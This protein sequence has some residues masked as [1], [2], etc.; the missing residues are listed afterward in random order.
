M[1]RSGS[2][3]VLLSTARAFAT[4]GAEHQ[5]VFVDHGRPATFVAD[6]TDLTDAF[7]EASQ[8]KHSG[9]QTQAGGTAGT[10]FVAR[11][12]VRVMRELDGILTPLLEA[13][14][15]VLAAWKTASHIERDPVS[16]PDPEEPATPVPGGGST[17]TP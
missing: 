1:P 3:E 15:P 13:N 8:R 12:A 10:D 14:P 17:P 11:R 2:Y 9:L 7:D 6:L 16:A 4:H 5:Q